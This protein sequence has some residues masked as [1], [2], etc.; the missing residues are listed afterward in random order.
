MTAKSFIVKPL[1]FSVF[2]AA[3]TAAGYDLTNMS[4]D[5]LGV[6]WKGV[7]GSTTHY[8][9]VDLGADTAVDF[10]SLLGC[11]AASAAWDIQI[12]AATA[13]QGPSF[14]TW[15]YASPQ[16]GFLAGSAALPSGRGIGWWSNGAPITARYWRIYIYKPSADI[17][18]V[19]RLVFG[20]KIIPD[21]EF[22]YGAAFGVRDLGTF[23]IS[24]RGVPLW[25]RNKTKLRTL[26]ITYANVYKN[27]VETALLPLA[28]QVGNELPV[29]I[30]TDGTADAQRQRRCYYGPLQG[31]L[32]AV[33][34]R[35]NGFEFRVNMVSFI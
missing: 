26:G 11:T 9:D 18:T 4:N 19:G 6:V 13:A 15:I 32:G 5:Y 17:V 1:P 35:A 29:F 3:A 7:A 25:R 10:I 14:G 16:V 22:V 8:F 24:P 33:W 2:S 31:D 34:A 20:S 27:E 30:C 23:D 21:R 28:E 12:L